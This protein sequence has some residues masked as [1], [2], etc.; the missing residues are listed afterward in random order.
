MNGEA[1]LPN[2]E[3]NLALLILENLVKNG[4]QATPR[5]Q[6]VKC[7]MAVA[8]SKLN[9]EVEDQGP[10]FPPALLNSL[11]KACRSTKAGGNGIGLAICKQLASHLGAELE[12]KRSDATGC[13]FALTLPRPK[14]G[15]SP[16]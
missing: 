8:E 6:S 15:S 4:L 12:L 14:S 9:I 2:R 5:G 3:A 13:V 10:G 7:R 16:V 11:F 1:V